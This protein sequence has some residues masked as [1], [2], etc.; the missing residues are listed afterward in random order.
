[1]RPKSMIASQLHTQLMWTFHLTPLG[2]CNPVSTASC[3]IPLILR[4]SC[5]YFPRDLENKM[6]AL[7]CS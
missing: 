7:L 4:V 1:M 5:L 3:H 6:W 2:C